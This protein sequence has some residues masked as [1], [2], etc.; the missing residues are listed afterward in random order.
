MDDDVVVLCYSDMIL[1]HPRI[2]ASTSETKNKKRNNGSWS[3]HQA[4]VENMRWRRKY[5][6]RYRYCCNCTGSTVH[7]EEGGIAVE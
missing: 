1:Q 5:M 3:A 2:A 6:Y 4:D 7:V